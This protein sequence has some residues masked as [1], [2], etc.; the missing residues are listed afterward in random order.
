MIYYKIYADNH[1]IGGVT[2][3]EMARWSD[4]RG[5]LLLF[6]TI[7]EAQYVIFGDKL[8]HASW[9]NPITGPMEYENAVL[10]ETDKEG[11]EEAILN[12]N[13]DV[14][15]DDDVED[16][17]DNTDVDIETNE[18]VF[19]MADLLEVIADHEERLCLM[20]LGVKA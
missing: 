14:T 16:Y 3:G 4:R 17:L 8:Y 5:G 15:A 10:E 20:E 7:G 11:Y 1:L 13:T 12:A 18:D 19:T 9:M 6:C 2:S